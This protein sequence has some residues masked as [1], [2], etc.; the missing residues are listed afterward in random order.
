MQLLA[1]GGCADPRAAAAHI[2]GAAEAVVVYEDLNDP[3]GIAVLS[4]SPNPNVFVDQVRPR[5]TTGP[6]P[7]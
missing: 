7:G 5:L 1:F 2:A 6:W 3:R 4:V